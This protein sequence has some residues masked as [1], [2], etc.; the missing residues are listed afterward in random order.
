MKCPVCGS[1]M[2]GLSIPWLRQC[3]QCGFYQSTLD[4]WIS[5][6]NDT[7]TLNEIKRS[8][9]LKPVR[10][11]S[12]RQVFGH[13]ASHKSKGELLDVG[14]GHGWFL[15]MAKEAGFNATGIEPDEFIWKEAK[16][17]GL[18]VRNGYFPD[19]LQSDEQFDV[20]CF[21][22]VF[23]HLPDIAQAAL[24]CRKHLKK[25]G[26]L[27]VNIPVSNGLLYRISKILARFGVMSPFER[28]WQKEFPSPHISYFSTEN[29]KHF[30]E[31]QGFEQVLDRPL[32][33]AE[34]SGLWQRVRYDQTKGML[35]SIF[36]YLIL[37]ALLPFLRVLP[38]DIQLQFFKLKDS[39][40]SG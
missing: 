14:C 33:S 6:S 5:D 31:K 16:K 34:L 17:T 35:Y 10:T 30:F 25:D 22:D 9:A 26:V 8:Q 24:A 32:R 3:R 15:E 28:L 7:S 23:E 18:S 29:L 27:S 12:F 4:I 11:L 37:L 2:T 38:S 13:L 19:V 36:S 40:N 1:R 39:K 20:I 21:N